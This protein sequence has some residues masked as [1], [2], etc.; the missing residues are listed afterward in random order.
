VG[1]V[2]AALSAVANFLFLPYC[3]VWSVLIIAL[4]VFVIW[5]LIVHGRRSPA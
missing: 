3:P 2:L 5:A 4:N 1:I